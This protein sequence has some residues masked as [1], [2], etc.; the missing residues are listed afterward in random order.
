VRPIEALAERTEWANVASSTVGLLL[1]FNLGVGWF[2]SRHRESLR[3]RLPA[4]AA[5]SRHETAGELAWLLAGGASL[6][7]LLA[8]LAVRGWHGPGPFFFALGG[9]AVLLVVTAL[10]L[11]LVLARHG[12]GCAA[13]RP[14]RLRHH[15]DDFEVRFGNRSFGERV[16]ELNAALLVGRR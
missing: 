13:E 1:F 9:W 2:H 3:L 4:C 16:A 8:T 10:T 11:S 7:G 12:P 5:C 14:V 15:G 6:V